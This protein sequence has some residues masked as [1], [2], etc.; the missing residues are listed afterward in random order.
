MSSA[1]KRHPWRWLLLV[2][3]SV[4]MGA[5]IVIAGL[6]K[7]VESAAALSA[8]GNPGHASGAS[9]FITL[10]LA[11]LLILLC[12]IV[13]AVKIVSGL[14]YNSRLKREAAEREERYF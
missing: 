12:L 6:V 14:R 1:R 7:E 5:G 10:P 3:A 11:A 4:I 2:I 13:A 9:L 8:A